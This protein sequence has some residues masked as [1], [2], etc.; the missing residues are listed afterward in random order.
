M[1]NLLGCLILMVSALANASAAGNS[2]DF[3]ERALAGLDRLPALSADVW[4]RQGIERESGDQRRSPF[5]GSQNINAAR[6]A[7]L[8]FGKLDARYGSYDQALRDAPIKRVNFATLRGLQAGVRADIVER[9]VREIAD[10]DEIEAPSVVRYKGKSY[11]MDG[12]HTL[13][14]LKL[15]GVRAVEAKVM[16][17]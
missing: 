7:E 13:T 12:Y 10:S 5:K 11:L 6:L 14:A 2:M 3:K 15:G 9:K 4:D 16:P 8:F 1:S 17:I